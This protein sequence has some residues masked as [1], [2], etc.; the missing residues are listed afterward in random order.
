MTAFKKALQGNSITIAF[1][2]G[3]LAKILDTD[4][5]GQGR[6]PLDVTHMNS[7]NGY[8]E[9]DPN[10]WAKVKSGKVTI[11]HDADLAPPIRGPAETI[12]VTEPL[13]SGQATPATWA[14]TGFMSDYQPTRKLREVVTAE[15]TLDFSGQPTITPSA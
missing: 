9:Q 2:T 14:C 3:F 4:V 1:S 11:Q 7:P 8:E 15:V 12:T 5:G 6:D 13:R 10:F